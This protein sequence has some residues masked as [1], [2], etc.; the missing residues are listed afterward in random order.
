MDRKRSVLNVTVSII[1]HIILLFSALIVRR[2]LIQNIG[3]DVNGLN[4]LYAN[5][6]GL[7]AVVELGIGSAITY[8]MYKPI[9]ADNKR[10]IAALFRV[11]T[12]TYK[13]VGVVIFFI[14]LTITPFLS[15]IIYDYDTVK[16]NVHFTFILALVA[17]VISYFYSAKTALI[18]AYKNNYITT[19]IRTISQLICYGLQIGAILIWRSF[20]IFL[21]CQIIETI[22]VWI[23]TEVTIR[24]KYGDII[25]RS[26]SL[27]RITRT[28]ITRNTKAMFM[29]EIGIV[30]VKTVDNLIISGFVGVVVLGKYSNYTHIAAVITGVISLLFKPLSSAVGHLC[31][32]KNNTEKQK[33][34]GWFYY[35]NFVLGFIFFLGYFAVVDGVIN[36]FF[37]PELQMPRSISFI[38]TL[39]QFNQYMRN[40][41]LLFRNASGAYYYDRWKAI[42]EGAVNLV[43]SLLFVMIFPEEY[44]V[45]GVIVAT[46]ITTL[47]ICNTVEPYVVFKHIFS[48]SPKT[49]YIRNYSYTGLFTICLLGMTFLIR[50]ETDSSVTGILINGLIAVGMSIVVLGLVVIV[51]KQFREEIQTFIQKSRELIHRRKAAS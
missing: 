26:G 39:N 9:V 3:N 11:Y 30:M 24:K 8:T 36:L 31:A 32:E 25:C 37:G 22:I 1:S 28:E 4:N 13:I 45:V 19:I 21:V 44:K 34:F 29:H 41:L 20:T 40:S 23:L 10:Q 42:V 7:L 18:E 16:V 50:E 5:I 43:L 15:R 17:A 27:D 35:L 51:D 49:F 33:W 6:I 14:G 12:K 47:T 48:S 2:L 46:I 38:I